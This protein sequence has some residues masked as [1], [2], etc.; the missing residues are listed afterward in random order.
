MYFLC[1]KF[2]QL[3]YLLIAIYRDKGPGPGEPKKARNVKKQK[4][5]TPPQKK[6]KKNT[7][8]ETEKY[9]GKTQQRNS[10]KKKTTYIRPT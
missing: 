3:T 1:F 6:T 10:K 5:N 8:T 2:I 9:T 4:D 7:L